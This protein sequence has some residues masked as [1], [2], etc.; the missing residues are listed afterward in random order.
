MSTLDGDDG[1]VFRATLPTR[2]MNRVWI[3]QMLPFMRPPRPSAV[4][5]LILLGVAVVVLSPSLPLRVGA[6]SGPSSPVP[7]F[8]GPLRDYASSVHRAAAFA[9][10]ASAKTSLTS[11][12]HL[13]SENVSI[14]VGSGDS[15]AFLDSTSGMVFVPNS[16]SGNVSVINGSDYRAVGSISGIQESYGGTYDPFNGYLYFPDY[17]TNDVAVVNATTDK[18]VTNISIAGAGPDAVVFDPSNR[19]VYVADYSGEVSVING[20]T[21]K[22]VGTISVGGYPLELAFDSITG[23]V[24]VTRGATGEVAVINATNNRLI[25]FAS[26]GTYPYELVFIPSLDEVCVSNLGGDNVTV[27]NASTYK[28]TGNISMGT[29]PAGLTYDAAQNTLIIADSTQ[30]EVTVVNASSDSLLGTIGLNG[31]DPFGVLYDNQSEALFV[32]YSSGN[33]VTALLPLIRAVVNGTPDPTDVGLGTEFTSSVNGGL[34]PYLAYNWSFGDSVDSNGSSPAIIHSYSHP[35]N[36]ELTVRVTD[37]GG[38]HSS[39]NLSV[40]VERDP[41]TGAVSTPV[42]RIDAGENATMIVSANNGVPPYRYSWTGLPKGCPVIRPGTVTCKWPE[43]G[44]WP[45]NVTVTDAV[46]E[47][48]PS[49]PTLTFTVLPDPT[50]GPV[51]ASR[52][53]ADVGQSVNLTAVVTGGTGT[54]VS[55][56]WSGLAG[57]NCNFTVGEWISCAF[58]QPGNYSISVSSVDSD[59]VGTDQSAPIVLRVFS[60]PLVNPPTASRISADVNQTVKFS[61]SA[62]GGY[63]SD[64]FLWSG[65]PT[66]CAGVAAR[67]ATVSCVMNSPGPLNVSVIVADANGGES[68]GSRASTVTV[69]SDPFLGRPTLSPQSVQEGQPLTVSVAVAG[70]SGDVKYAWSGLPAGCSG[71]GATIRCI[72]TEAGSFRVSVDV[73]DSDGYGAHSPVS[74]LIVTPSPASPTFLGLPVTEGYGVLG[75]VLVAILIVTMAAVLLRRRG[76]KPYC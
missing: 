6:S 11:T 64:M 51:G 48:S 69:Y 73:N 26:A 71:T 4:K 9:F 47:T 52:T 42:S 68:A 37:S 10:L 8:S 30:S 46:G 34:A 27:L 25:G 62:S 32:G 41:S 29:S 38:F 5:L 7:A 58:G 33:N 74:T 63:G 53:S 61:T 56:H 50:I 43:S 36:Y 2:W 66:D 45:V 59:G 28:P 16:I 49:G 12:T 60:L 22:N 55:Y 67:T 19:L 23:A 76:G 72:P 17:T 1:H 57:A 3:F 21:N 35:G 13:H 40:I 14:P 65:L 44:N 15:N 39:A 31:N 75:G 18:L 24:L 20:S 54:Y 70:G